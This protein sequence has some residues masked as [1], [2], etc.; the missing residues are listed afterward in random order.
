MAQTLEDM[1]EVLSY[2]KNQNLGFFI[3]YTLNGEEHRY[4]PDF[5]VRLA[6]DDGELVT[7][8]LEVSGQQKKEKVAKVAAARNLWV[9]A[10][11]NH[12][13]FG[14]WDFIEISDPWDAEN[15]LRAHLATQATTKAP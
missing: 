15:T 5:L 7:L 2:A 6:T 11:N 8:I 1:P 9:P 10:M 3:P 4:L 12:G 14:R 13:G